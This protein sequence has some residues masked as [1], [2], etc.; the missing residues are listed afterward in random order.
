MDG[1]APAGAAVERSSAIDVLTVHDYSGG[2]E[3]DPA[4]ATTMAR[5][6][7]IGKPVLLE[8]VGI[9]GR[10]RRGCR[11]TRNRAFQ[12]EAKASAAVA[13]GADGVLLWAYGE[14]ATGCDY[15]IG[16]DDPAFALLRNP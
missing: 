1:R 16:P 13:R 6:T 7:Q 4:G 8:E 10:D 12:L 14:G 3:L 9:N 2:V 15:Y 11:S 5:A